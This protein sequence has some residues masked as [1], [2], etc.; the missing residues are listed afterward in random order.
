MDGKSNLK[1]LSTKQMAENFTEIVRDLFCGAVR[2]KSAKTPP[3]G[4]LFEKTREMLRA[5]P[6]NCGCLWTMIL[7]FR[8]WRTA[9]KSGHLL[10][11][12]RVYRFLAEARLDPKSKP[13]GPSTS[14]SRSANPVRNLGEV[15]AEFGR[16]GF[17]KG[18]RPGMAGNLSASIGRIMRAF[19]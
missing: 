8:R 5:W 12:V 15:F 1:T 4:E 19:D 16:N 18:R 13:D 3:N 11:A 7:R 9:G 2:P 17:L 14:N 6:G 10:L